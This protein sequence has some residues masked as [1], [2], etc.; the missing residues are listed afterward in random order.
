VH[1]LVEDV[2]NREGDMVS[3]LWVLGL[4]GNRGVERELIV[5][6]LIE[7]V[8][9]PEPEVRHWSIEALGKIGSNEVIPIL[10]DA[11]RF[12]PQAQEWVYQALREITGEG[13]G[14]DATTWR[15]WAARRG[16]L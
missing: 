7:T 10:T 4:L 6:E 14:N 2:Q 13:I 15:N 11:F 12:E 9:D 5:R 16:L 8:K 1:K 3:N